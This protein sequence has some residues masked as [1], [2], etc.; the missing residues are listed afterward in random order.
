M[1]SVRDPESLSESEQR[2]LSV[3]SCLLPAKVASSALV[4]R[5]LLIY[6]VDEE[7]IH[8]RSLPLQFQAQLIPQCLLEICLPVVLVF[9]RR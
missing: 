1:H 7:D 3:L 6:M 4:L 5:R 8:R 9:M 2:P